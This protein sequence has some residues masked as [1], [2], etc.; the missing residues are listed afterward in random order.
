MPNKPAQ[1]C[2][3]NNAATLHTVL[4]FPWRGVLHTVTWPSVVLPLEDRGR[5]RKLTLWA[6]GWWP[7]A[8]RTHLW[9]GADVRSGEQLLLRDDCKLYIVSSS[10]IMHSKLSWKRYYCSFVLTNQLY[11]QVCFYLV[12][13]LSRC[14]Y[15]KYKYLSF[16]V[17]L[18]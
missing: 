17:F 16:V 13:N 15:S 1:L 18:F 11:Y 5:R 10:L 9:G 8:G 2:M 12:L 4:R 7:E 6:H 3:Y 14:H